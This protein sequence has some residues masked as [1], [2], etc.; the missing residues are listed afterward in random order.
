LVLAILLPRP[1]FVVIVFLWLCVMLFIASLVTGSPPSS[2]E[3][4]RFFIPGRW[5]CRFSTWRANP[6]VVVQPFV[7]VTAHL[8][9]V[10]PVVKLLKQLQS[11]FLKSCVL[12]VRILGYRIWEYP[13][14]FFCTIRLI[15][16][17]WKSA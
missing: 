5:R 15:E 10:S 12:R 3:K 7:V 16:R 17:R 9:I 1:Y 13:L 6:A 4:Y 2:L 8:R 14:S 11:S